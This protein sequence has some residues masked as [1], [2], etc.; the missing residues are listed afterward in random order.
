MGLDFSKKGIYL[1]VIGGLLSALN[2]LSFADMLSRCAKRSPRF[3]FKVNSASRKAKSWVIEGYQLI[4]LML[5][6]IAL[7]NMPHDRTAWTNLWWVAV[8][9][10]AHYRPV[11]IA[12]YSA[13]WLLVDEVPLHAY[14]RS[15]ISLLINLLEVSISMTLL[16]LPSGAHSERW[17]RVWDNLGGAFKLDVPTLG[18]PYALWFSLETGLLLLFLV[19]CVIGGIQREEID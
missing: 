16:G 7:W 11:E 9:F 15:L 3:S 5:L 18:E 17:C 6:V 1:T 10:L 19:A 13:K 12:V 14:R 2:R 8:V 4:I